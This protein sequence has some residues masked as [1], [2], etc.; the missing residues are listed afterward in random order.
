MTDTW[1]IYRAGQASAATSTPGTPPTLGLAYDL[2][3]GQWVST[4]QYSQ[5]IRDT[6]SIAQRQTI[7]QAEAERQRTLYELELEKAHNIQSTGLPTEDD[8]STFE[9]VGSFFGHLIKEPKRLYDETFGDSSS[10]DS[11]DERADAYASYRAAGGVLSEEDFNS[12]DGYTRSK[13]VTNAEVAK[14]MGDVFSTPGISHT[15]QGLEYGYRG[16]SVPFYMIHQSANRNPNNVPLNLS[17]VLNPMWFDGSKYA[18]A[19]R[20]SSD[21]T[22]G[23]EILNSILSPYTS[24]ETLDE[25]SRNNSFYQFSSLG[26]E[27]LATWYMDPSVIAAKGLGGIARHTRGEIPRNSYLQRG[28]RQALQ[29]ESITLRAPGTKQYASWRANQLDSAMDS[30]VEAARTMTYGEFAQASMFRGQAIAGAPAAH[31]LHYAANSGDDALLDLTKQLLYGDPKAYAQLKTLEKDTP[32]QLRKFAPKAQTVLDAVGAAKTRIKQLEDET[33]KLSKALPLDDSGKLPM[34]AP[35][36]QWER[37]TDLQAAKAE[38]SELTDVLRKYEPYET[39][40]EL[41]TGA[42]GAKPLINQVKKPR[43]TRRTFLGGPFGKA[44]SVVKLPRAV[45]VQRAGLIGMHDLDSGSRSINR[46]FDQMEHLMG[47]ADNEAR[48]TALNGWVSAP[49]NYDR[50]KMLYELEEAHLPKALSNRFGVSEE[51]ARELMNKINSEQNLTKQA[52]LNM[53][54]SVYSSAPSLGAR[55]ADPSHEGIKLIEVDEEGIATIELLDNT[56]H[57]VTIQVPE[58]ALTERKVPLDPT[59]TP[60][61]YQPIDTRRMFLEFKRHK[62]LIQTLDV[63]LAASGRAG[64]M[65]AVDVVG[66]KF[67]QFWKPF[68]LFRLG[69]P[70]RVL[71]DE[72]MRAMAVFGPMYWLTGAGS[73]AF[74]TSVSNIPFHMRNK[75]QRK[76]RVPLGEGPVTRAEKINAEP[77][78]RAKTQAQ[79]VKIPHLSF[80]KVNSERFAKINETAANFSAWKR[81]HDYLKAWD[82]AYDDM[83]R[84]QP[85]SLDYDH[86]VRGTR[87]YEAAQAE[88]MEKVYKP[89]ITRVGGNI[90]DEFGAL[91]DNLPMLKTLITNH[92]GTYPKH[93]IEDVYFD[94]ELFMDKGEFA[95]RGPLVHDAATGQKV[96]SGYIV[97][98]PDP[99]F[100]GPNLKFL[101]P[102]EYHNMMFWYEQNA[103]V[104]ARSG[105]RIVSDHEGNLTIGK[106]FRSNEFNKAREFA[107][108]VDD[109]FPGAKMW[110]IGKGK[111]FHVVDANATSPFLE[112]LN[113]YFPGDEVIER[114]KGNA[115]IEGE[116]KGGAMQKQPG[117]VIH[118]SDD[119][120]MHTKDLLGR[121]AVPVVTGR[122]IG[123]GLYT[124]TSEDIVRGYNFLKLYQIRGSKSGRQHKVFDLDRV[125]GQRQIEDFMAW[126][127]TRKFEYGLDDYD[128]PALEQTFR[129]G[130]FHSYHTRTFGSQ[131]TT[132][133]NAFEAMD[134]AGRPQW[135][136]ALTNYLEEKFAAGV[137]HHKGGGSTGNDHHVYIWLQPEDLEL[138]PLYS[139]TGK[140]V[141]LLQWL[142]RPESLENLVP[143]DRLI[144]KGLRNPMLRS[145]RTLANQI[146][147]KESTL[148]GKAR[149]TDPEYRELLVREQ[150]LMDALG[151]EYR[152][153]V[154][155]PGGR[156]GLLVVEDSPTQA[157]LP[158]RYVTFDKDR[159]NRMV[160]EASAEDARRG[161]AA[162]ARG[163]LRAQERMVEDQFE[164]MDDFDFQI[165]SVLGRVAQKIFDQRKLGH[166]YQVMRSSD[167]QQFTVENAFQ[168]HQGELMRGL[169]G[170]SRTLDVL[171]EGH[172]GAL[173]A[174][175]RRAAGYRTYNPVPLTSEALK[176]GTKANKKAVRYFNA[177]SEVLNDQ[178]AHSPIWSK[179]LRGWDDDRI[180]RWLESSPE[181]AKIRREVAPLSYRDAPE[182]WVHEH[183]AK[184]D[185]YLPDRNMQ[186][187]LAKGRID[188]SELRKQ[189]NEENFPTVYGPDVEILDKRRGFGQFISDMTDK[190]YHALG[191][192]PIDAMSRHPFA[193][194]VYDAKLRALISATDSKWLD[195][196][197]IKD[198]Q[199]QA[200]QFAMDQVRRTL[201]D[202]T[203]QTNF[204]D[205]LRFIAPF[206]GAQQEAITKWLRIIA[207]RP[208][209]VA[210]FFAG[211]RAVY[212]N[213]VVIDE[214]G[215][216]VDRGTR[217]GG[218]HD[219]GL[220]H[221]EDRV[222]LSIPESMR[223]GPLGK[224]LMTV[225][226]IGVPI[227]SAN[228]V[229]QGELPLFPSLGPMVTVPANEFLRAFSDTYGVEHDEDLWYRWL[230]PVGRP[231]SKSMVG[232]VMEQISPGWAK[233]VQSMTGPENDAAKANLFF[234]VHREM[235]LEAQRKGEPPPTE[236]EVAAQTNWL[237]GLR[238]VAGMVMPVQTEFRPKN[239]FFID[240]F[241]R[242]QQE[243]GPDAWDKFID[244]FGPAMATYASSSSSS[245]GVPP[246]SEGMEQWSA[247]KDLI[248]A[249][250]DWA[251]AIVSP[252]AYA[253]DFSFDAYYAQFDINLGPGSSG[254][255]REVVSPED[256]I[257][258]ANRRLGWREWRQFGAAMDAELY[259]RGLTDIRQSGAE[260][261]LNL[262][263]SFIS[264]LM[265]RNSDWYE[266]YE[267]TGNNIYT[268][269]NQL[270]QIAFDPRFDKRPDMQGVRQYLI[271][272][273]SVAAQLDLIGSQGGSRSLQAQDNA[274][275]A[276]WFYSQVGAL[277]QANPAFEE[278]Y[279]RY[280]EQDTL[281]RGSG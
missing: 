29:R 140:Y 253:D 8:S 177:W 37:Y 70:Q 14:N 125:I 58:E 113:R 96:K 22:P 30:V 268:R 89:F 104:L 5:M 180:A 3:T 264:D 190:V 211:Q 87:D 166:G 214:E 276:S 34:Q 232:R 149:H 111:S 182:L 244:D 76:G 2:S 21:T 54:G 155:G 62:D 55:I 143:E 100:A 195:D 197:A 176:P 279:A 39:W 235:S 163:E 129:T 257:R 25:W 194:A 172:G 98:I 281:E 265:N 110:D 44:H 77:F 15:L 117:D 154:G 173:A 280:L 91:I 277:R 63:G 208:E 151:L 153:R 43:E 142:Q 219:F 174:N 243:F 86:T 81:Q 17:N 131:G 132:W 256:R 212:N 148:Q 147:E 254:S 122:R 114:T 181:G 135:Q 241:H 47:Y 71:M 138:K 20:E 12:F 263:R 10:G 75:V 209:T 245:V 107:Q 150:E 52:I 215:N 85:K 230:F 35:F 112:Q 237:W 234:Q 226:S 66:T 136:Q 116:L 202:L 83:L 252:D 246:T 258:E 92:Q 274:Y 79:S 186:R 184:L 26:T 175:R 4:S 126:I 196:V 38:V 242:Y 228:T 11:D 216:P 210:R 275:L 250:P 90:S 72:G 267:Q 141:P 16:L 144:R 49:T 56:N 221:P 108:M 73:E 130:R 80:P 179:M 134:D 119:R 170:S 9:T 84:T 115:P 13:L 18:Q 198:M 233:R 207:D 61:Y 156:E 78:A 95:A 28:V 109:S 164:A 157:T 218:L 53:K 127:D 222:V 199:E 273:E 205:A 193:K 213:F 269:M 168:G 120:N 272:R 251:S 23:N 97:P 203:D 124:S 103:E 162:L 93:P 255:L 189:I 160:D 123:S 206:W 229:L 167:G 225:G 41:A 106:H 7:A 187:K 105:I 188:P 236:A 48:D 46:I 227:G 101:K 201:F 40:L 183:R 278:F 262:Q 118:G 139:K 185:Y 192:V 152:S 33:A 224:A 178:I 231:K 169:I 50:Y 161:K 158:D 60:N 27:I 42:H 238:I 51:F 146:A 31:M 99:Q 6:A 247:N 240:T 133:G 270:T 248:A 94:N 64:L 68:Q 200:R 204:T 261:L 266:D 19:W 88:W 145:L 220:Y 102:N 260:D 165:D 128:L 36:F 137:L 69:W 65:E 82:R 217:E 159:F 74:R 121:D 24:E 67:N 191:T 259:S 239:Q 59:Q 171:T 223:K 45:F 271:L 57:K 32:E 1:S 249:Y